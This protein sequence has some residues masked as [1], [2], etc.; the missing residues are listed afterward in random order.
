[1]ELH[2]YLLLQLIVTNPLC[3]VSI[4]IIAHGGNMS[5]FYAFYRIVFSVDDDDPVWVGSYGRSCFR[6]KQSCFQLCLSN[7]D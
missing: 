7:K 5:R 3:V 4:M 1:M 2:G 6:T